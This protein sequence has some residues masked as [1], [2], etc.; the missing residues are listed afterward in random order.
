MT[1]NLKSINHLD[2][3]LFIVLIISG[4]EIKLIIILAGLIDTIAICEYEGYAGQP[5]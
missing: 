3:N 4:F 5:R 1:K 2:K